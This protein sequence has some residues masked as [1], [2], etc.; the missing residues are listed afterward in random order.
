[1][2]DEF[3]FDAVDPAFARLQAADPGLLAQPDVARLRTRIDA[4]VAATPT[5]E[6]GA[7]RSRRGVFVGAAAATVGA[8]VIGWGGF[9]VGAA[10][11]ATSAA[12]AGTGASPGTSYA[13]SATPGSAALP[14]TNLS[15]TATGGVGAAPLA[16]TMS[17]TQ[18]KPAPFAR[19]HYSTMGFGSM[20]AIAN[21]NYLAVQ[22]LSD[23]AGTASAYVYAPMTRSEVQAKALI[24]ARAF[25]LVS[26]KVTTTSSQLMLRA[27]QGV[28]TVGLT[29]AVPFGYQSYGSAGTVVPS[30]ESSISAGQSVLKAVRPDLF[31]NSLLRVHGV[32]APGANVVTFTP[33]I[34]G[35]GSP[36][37]WQFVYSGKQQISKAFGQLATVSSLGSYKTIGA[38]SAALRLGGSANYQPRV[39]PILL[40]H[41][42][43]FVD[44]TGSATSST[45]TAVIP[46]ERL[47]VAAPTLWL[48]AASLE[49]GEYVLSGGQAVLLPTYVYWTSSGSQIGVLALADAALVSTK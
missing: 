12:S 8:L 29:G 45:K 41:A 16:T 7:R 25:G 4:A 28:L 38:K 32:A 1:M 40:G 14:Q 3:G 30:V 21:Y 13:K 20:S 19:D 49:L 11:T 27:P 18:S 15:A 9:A 22:A 26:P 31:T 23:K 39:V 46:G 17:P 48:T 47:A 2:N 43:A 6:L 33:V 5:D 44:N 35:L 36:L 10:S 34:G 42:P 24:L 37:P